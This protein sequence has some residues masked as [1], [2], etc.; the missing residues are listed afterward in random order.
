MQ[1][2]N[3]DLLLGNELGQDTCVSAEEHFGNSDPNSINFKIVLKMDT[4]GP[5]GKMLWGKADHSISRQEPGRINWEQ[6][7]LDKSTSDM[8][9]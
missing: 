3:L 5:W 2:T 8:W 4:P 9:E 7:L 1:R 6:L